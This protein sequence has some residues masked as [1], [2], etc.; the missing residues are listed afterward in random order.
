MSFYINLI[1]L[2]VGVLTLSG[3]D[4]SADLNNYDKNDATVKLRTESLDTSNWGKYISEKYNFTMLYPSEL[5]VNEEIALEGTSSEHYS[6]VFTKGRE[7]GYLVIAPDTTDGFRLL[8]EFN[9]DEQIIDGK[10]VF[11]EEWS[12]GRYSNLKFI[13]QIDKWKMCDE[14]AF[15]VHISFFG[16]D[17]EVFKKMIS[18]IDFISD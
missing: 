10:K 15:C 2:V 16:S 4:S 17:F 6:I 3:C 9:S 13:D 18:T 11:V 1:L 7:F 12:G 8:E 14:T 5:T